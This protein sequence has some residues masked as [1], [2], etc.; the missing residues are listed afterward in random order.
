MIPILWSRHCKATCP[1]CGFKYGSDALSP[2]VLA[3]LV[4]NDSSETIRLAAL[5][6][7]ISSSN[8]TSD[9]LRSTAELAL[10]DPDVDVRTQARD[11]LDQM[12]ASEA[13]V[14]AKGPD[15]Q[16]IAR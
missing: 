12:Q 13:L 2:D 7:I 1:M 10:S 8:A 9:Q 15:L 16:E 5:R 11:I 14:S 3:T 6:L 4:H